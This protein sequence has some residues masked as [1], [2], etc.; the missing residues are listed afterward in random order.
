MWPRGAPIIL[1]TAKSFLRE[2][3]ELAKST[4]RITADMATTM[5]SKTS[6]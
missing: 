6:T 1:S 4:A 3:T 5:S 2:P